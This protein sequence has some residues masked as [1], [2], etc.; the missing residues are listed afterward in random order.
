MTGMVTAPP[1]RP[2]VAGPKM[3]ARLRGRAF[4]AALV[5]VSLW[6]AVQNLANLAVPRHLVDELVYVTA[7]WR[8]LHGQQL[9]LGPAAEFTVDNFEHPPLVKYLFGIAQV[10]AGHPSLTAAR[11]VAA[12][13]TLATG[14]VLGCWIGRVAGRWTGL[15]AGALITLVPTHIP[16]VEYR[17]GRYAML[18]PVAELFAVGAVAAGWFWFQ[19]RG[20]AGWRWAAS[21]GVLA[22]LAAGAKA[23][24]FLGLVG[25]VL[26]GLVLVLRER[27]ELIDRLA[28]TVAAGALS[29]LTF[30]ALYLPLG[31]PLPRIRFL[32]EYQLKHVEDGH[33]IGF[34]GRVTAHP[35][36][37]AN[38]WFAGHGLGSVVVGVLV[39]GWV[40]A[41]VLR[42]DRL[43]GWCAAALVAPVLF[44]CFLARVVL[45]F[46]W[47]MWLPAAIAAAALG[48][49]ALA[50]RS[51]AAPRG[52]R[53]GA[54]A[55]LIGALTWTAG[56]AAADTWRTL[57]ARPV[58]TAHLPKVMA[59]HHLR[60]E[61]LAGGLYNWEFTGV[62]LPGAVLYQV[63]ADLSRVDT[64][65]IGRPRCRTPVAADV[66][67]FLTANRGA[68]RPVYRDHLIVVHAVRARLRAPTAAEIA[69]QPPW[70]LAAHC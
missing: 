29:A 12:A 69:A 10:I 3:P 48:L 51:R 24:G 36:W 42:R 56:L 2:V 6:A 27:R 49:A 18:D 33:L 26:L 15:L 62:P 50:R 60:G 38:L 21:A 17:F 57:H 20:R 64:V 28:Q 46:Y 47:A 39:I 14:V 16:G 34:A 23:N 8:Y 41:L 4:P 63:P 70:N 11:L 52:V 25:P 37:W 32:L 30:V 35:P 22:G 40:A 5:A 58:G 66:R 7:G 67:A 53:S 45:G 54:A 13:C 68:L 43:V 19:R 44:H 65:V 55:L 9:P 61:V 1:R 31:N 59:L